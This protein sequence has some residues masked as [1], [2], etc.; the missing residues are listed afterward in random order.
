MSAMICLLSWLLLAAL[1][2]VG[3]RMED[4]VDLM[5]WVPRIIG[6]SWTLMAL[7]R[8]VETGSGLMFFTALWLLGFTMHQFSKKDRE[9]A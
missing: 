7:D 4:D 1:A 3:W 8:F 6:A 9:N 2:L 5:E